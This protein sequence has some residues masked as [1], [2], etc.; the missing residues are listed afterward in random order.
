M[1]NFYVELEPTK[2]EKIEIEKSI[3]LCKKHGHK[4]EVDSNCGPE[5]ASET[6][7][8]TRCGESPNEIIYY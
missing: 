6:F 3:K 7:T 5:S 1:S 2:E 4:W 8:C